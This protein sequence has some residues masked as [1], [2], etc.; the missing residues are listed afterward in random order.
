MNYKGSCHC[1]QVSFEVEGDLQQ[2]VEC[3]C[4][5]CSR[6]GLLLWAVPRSQLKLLRTEGVSTYKFNKHMIEHKFCPNCGAQPF[7]YGK[8]TSGNELTAINVR[9]LSDVDLSS[10]KRIPF[11]GRSL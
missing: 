2:V 5:I 8:D 4:S 1:G 10:L 11:D 9:C 7:S 3:N 6:K